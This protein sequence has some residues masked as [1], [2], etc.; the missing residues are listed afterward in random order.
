M[1]LISTDYSTIAQMRHS[2]D[3]LLP[4]RKEFS[5]IYLP[6]L[7]TTSGIY[8]MLFYAMNSIRLLLLFG[9]ICCCLAVPQSIVVSGN[10]PRVPIPSPDTPVEP[11]GTTSAVGQTFHPLYPENYDEFNVTDSGDRPHVAKR[12][13]PVPLWDKHY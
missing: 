6:A 11:Q 8:A 13:I 9:V 3:V 10:T 4:A 2:H 7:L 1:T 5:L 12:G